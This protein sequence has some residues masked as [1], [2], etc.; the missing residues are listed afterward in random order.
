MFRHLPKSSPERAGRSGYAR[1]VVSAHDVAALI[2][3]EQHDHGHQVDKMQLQKLLYLVDGAHLVF[4]DEPAFRED[5]RAYVNGP[6]VEVVEQTYREA[7]PGAE[8]LPRA[9]GGDPSR[10]DD[11]RVDTI[12]TV[13]RYFGAWAAP[14]LEHYVKRGSDNPWKSARDRAGAALDDRVRPTMDRAE[15]A[16][17]FHHHGVDPNPPRTSPWNPTDERVHEIDERLDRAGAV[18]TFGPAGIDEVRPF[19][20]RALAQRD[21]E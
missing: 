15:V 7:T 14:N 6:V 3:E 13:L 5:L 2:I 8:P 4:W 20:E 1:D 9:L 16:A 17:W 12:Q 10:L 21:H 19:V 18:G 11:D